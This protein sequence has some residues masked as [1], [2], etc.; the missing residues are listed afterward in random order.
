METSILRKPLHIL[1]VL[2]MTAS[3]LATAAVGAFAQT[4]TDV[5]DDHPFAEEIGWMVENEITTGFADDTFRPTIDVTR[6]AAVTFI[7]RWAGSPDVTEPADFTDIDAVPDEFADAIA[8]AVEA[9]ITTGFGDDTF[10]PT[11]PVTRRAFSAWLFRANGEPE[12]EFAA[13][14]IAEF[15]DVDAD[16]DFVNEIGWM[17]AN[18]ITTGFGDDTFRPGEN[19]TRQATAAFLFRY[20]ELVAEVEPLEFRALSIDPDKEAV[21][22]SDGAAVIEFPY[23]DDAFQVNGVNATQASFE[24][25]VEGNA[26]HVILSATPQADG[27]F[28]HDVVAGE[29]VLS[30][31]VGNGTAEPFEDAS[32]TVPVPG[33]GTGFAIVDAPS[34]DILTEIT[35]VLAGLAGG[36]DS[37]LYTVDG[38]AVAGGTFLENLSVGD[39]IEAEILVVDGDDI[40]TVRHNLVNGTLEG[41]ISSTAGTEGAPELPAVIDTV[42]DDDGTEVNVQLYT[43]PDG[44]EDDVTFIVDGDEVDDLAAFNGELEEGATLTYSFAANAAVYTVE[45]LEPEVFE[46]VTGTIIDGVI[47]ADA[48]VVTLAVLADG[49]LVTIDIDGDATFVIDGFTS[50]ADEFDSDASFGDTVSCTAGELSDDADVYADCSALVLDNVETISAPVVFDDEGDVALALGDF[51]LPLAA[52]DDGVVF[53]VTNADEGAFVINGETEFDGVTVDFGFVAS[54]L[55]ATSLDVVD[56]TATFTHVDGEDGVW[57]FD[58]VP[59]SAINA[60]VAAD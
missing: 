57:E 22:L 25:F 41:V 56:V 2:A 45:T 20:D 34:G 51:D 60:A 18:G 10:R 37:V 7:Y 5:P 9:G 31:V 54:A 19:V 42:P 26:P 27:S 17:A 35:D 36:I 1:L 23:E 8:W 28:V 21:L 46:P 32:T 59:Q 44:T 14:A 29:V 11:D 53:N 40:V 13:I 52:T 3:L 58:G 12:G 15:D 16:T 30:G 24:A 33:T 50:L 49:E 43:T 48:A 55:S 38:A 39:S 4:F 47:D 6:M